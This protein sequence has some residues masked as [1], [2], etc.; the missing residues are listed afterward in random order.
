MSEKFNQ[1]KYINEWAKEN[2]GTVMGKYKK[3]FVAEFKDACKTLGIS[4]SDVIRQA[5]I[6]T[7]EKSKNKG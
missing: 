4:Q 7:I 6:E 5:M 1:S 3:D 2:M